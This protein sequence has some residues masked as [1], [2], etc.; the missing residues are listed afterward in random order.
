MSFETQT[1][2]DLLV[3]AS[4]WASILSMYNDI[5]IHPAHDVPLMGQEPAPKKI[6]IRSDRSSH[7]FALNYSRKSK[8]S[9]PE[10]FPL[11]SE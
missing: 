4:D 8:S 9:F 6:Q 1:N 11:I 7:W 3:K 10:R 2:F 5:E